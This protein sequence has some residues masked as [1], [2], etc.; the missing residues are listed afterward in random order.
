MRGCLPDSRVVNPGSRDA[1]CSKPQTEPVQLVVFPGWSGPLAVFCPLDRAGA[2]WSRALGRMRQ[3]NRLRSSRTGVTLRQ[4]SLQ[5]T[6]SSEHNRSERRK[7]GRGRHVPAP[8][9]EGRRATDRSQREGPKPEDW[10]AQ[11]LTCEVTSSAERETARAPTQRLDTLATNPDKPTQPTFL[12][13]FSSEDREDGLRTRAPTQRLVLRWY[14]TRQQEH[15]IVQDR[16]MQDQRPL[17]RFGK[18]PS[19]GSF[20]LRLYR[21]TPWQRSQIN[22][23]HSGP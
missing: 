12:T 15:R 11:A 9:G 3:I 22:P 7:S 23:Q 19:H 1:P 18:S 14:E 6:Q 13:Q 8:K 5:P 20:Q 21:D 4:V 10:R 16:T 2:E 17:S